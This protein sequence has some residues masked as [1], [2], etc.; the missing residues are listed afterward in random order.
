MEDIDEK[1][2]KWALQAGAKVLQQMDEPTVERIQTC[3]VL[4]IYWFSRDEP[5]RNNLFTGE[6]PVVQISITQS[7]TSFAQGIAYRA[8]R[9]LVIA[10]NDSSVSADSMTSE[11]IARMFWATWTQE[12][13]N[14]D[15]YIVG[16][17]LD[18]QLMRI[19]LPASDKAFYAGITESQGSLGDDASVSSGSPTSSDLSNASVMAETMKLVLIW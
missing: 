12:C 7:L 4:G 18:S 14:A 3:Q 6:N 5:Q 17:S 11:L 10:R 15:H 13:I 19:E 9:T 1:A 2:R 16:S 8:L